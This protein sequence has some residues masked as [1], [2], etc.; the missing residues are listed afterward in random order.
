[1]KFT[2]STLA[3]LSMPGLSLATYFSGTIKIENLTPVE[4]LGPTLTPSKLSL[5]GIAV[6]VVAVVLLMLQPF[7]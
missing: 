6:L 2:A 1:M 5:R 3:L 7:P 4:P